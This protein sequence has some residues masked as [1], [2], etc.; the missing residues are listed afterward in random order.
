MHM[1][2]RNDVDVL[3]FVSHTQRTQFEFEFEPLK[4]N[5]PQNVNFPPFKAKA[6]WQSK[7]FFQNGGAL[8]FTDT[9]TRGRLCG[10]AAHQKHWELQP[11]SDPGNL[12]APGPSDKEPT[13]FDA[14]ISL[15][16]CQK[17]GVGPP[18]DSI[19]FTLARR[20][21]QMRPFLPSRCI[22]HALRQIGEAKRKKTSASFST[23]G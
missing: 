23:F 3:I 7:F 1:W 12:C 6:K 15:S 18:W 11:L 17:V 14:D 22:S 8:C 2:L 16:P 13:V 21:K 9:A 19:S 10:I 4:E 5:F 20:K